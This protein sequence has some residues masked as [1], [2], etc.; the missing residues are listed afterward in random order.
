MLQLS[1]R[2]VVPPRAGGRPA[3]RTVWLRKA[4]ALPI[5]ER[6]AAISLVAALWG[7]RTV[8][9][10]L[11]VWGGVAAAYEVAGRLA[12]SLR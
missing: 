1:W 9:V 4:I 11:L 5:G 10:V 7:A 8:F 12:R 3:G 2:E 6:F